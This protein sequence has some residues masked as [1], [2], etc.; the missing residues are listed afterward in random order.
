MVD[1]AWFFSTLAQSAAAVIAFTIAFASVLFN[2]RID[3]LQAN[4][5][6]LRQEF[7]NL[8]EKY[9]EVLRSMAHGL[10]EEA[11]LEDPRDVNARALIDQYGTA[12]AAA[13]IQ[14]E[15]QRL[16]LT[17]DGID[18]WA[19]NQP[20]PT[21]AKAWAHL[22]RSAGHLNDVMG[23]TSNLLNLDDVHQ[24]RDSANILTE[25]FDDTNGG[26]E[27]IYE[28]LADTNPDT[29]YRSESII[30]APDSL[31]PWLEEHM[32]SIDER[33]TGWP[34][35]QDT[36][37][38]TNIISYTIVSDEFRRDI[39]N[40]LQN[41][42]GTKLLPLPDP[43]TAAKRLLIITLGLGTAGILLP[44]LFLITPSETLQISLTA[45]RIQI[46]QILLLVGSVLFTGL[47]FRELYNFI[48]QRAKDI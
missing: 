4:T 20:D 22:L 19:D 8:R 34:D 11:E 46:A 6:A 9:A 30:E 39:Y 12:Q 42:P 23:L 21:A 7:I 25:I 43:V 24:L 36:T 27:D 1:P 29:N 5:D 28:E 40:L 2:S 14:R 35:L 16:E 26:T 18:E 15:S 13:M 48:T 31:V 17:N 3:S 32:P 10:R 44:L 33:R 37:D 47:L 45:F 38:G 41:I